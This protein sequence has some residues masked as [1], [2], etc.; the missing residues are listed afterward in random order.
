MPKLKPAIALIAFLCIT[1]L[2]ASMIFIPEEKSKDI[3]VTGFAKYPQTQFYLIVIKDEL[4]VRPVTKWAILVNCDE[5]D[6]AYIS[7]QPFLK[8]YKSGMPYG[9]HTYEYKRFMQ[10]VSYTADDYEKGFVTQTQRIWFDYWNGAFNHFPRRRTL[11]YDLRQVDKGLYIWTKYALIPDHSFIKIPIPTRDYVY[12]MTPVIRSQEKCWL[13][14]WVERNFNRKKLTILYNKTIGQYGHEAVLR[15]SYQHIE[16]VMKEYY[17]LYLM[18]FLFAASVNVVAEL[19]ILLTLFSSITGIPLKKKVFALI[20]TSLLGNGF[21]IIML[22]WFLPL[23]RNTYMKLNMGGVF[24]AFLF[25]AIVYSLL[26]R[27]KLK[28]ALSLSFVC[29]LASYI[30]GLWLFMIVK[31][32]I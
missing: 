21:T 10:S 18:F 32:F 17:L 28:H 22:W 8:K 27:I 9:P 24:F 6:R 13:R 5:G 25:E 3:Y 7:W 4:I 11:V 30:L 1:A 14:N 23:W 20:P 12:N 26:V 16:W 29:N 19:I 31:L 2:S 15:D